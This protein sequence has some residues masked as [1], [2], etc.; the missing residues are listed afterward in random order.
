MH[1]SNIQ[2]I[3]LPFDCFH[4]FNNF[5][6]CQSVTSIIFVRGAFGFE[7]KAPELNQRIVVTTR[8]HETEGVR[9]AIAACEPTEVQKV[10]GAGHKGRCFENLEE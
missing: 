4:D 8:S 1:L 9:N 2:L 3:C 7:L 10:G 6:I 5:T